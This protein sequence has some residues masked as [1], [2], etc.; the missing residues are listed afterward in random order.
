M[1]WWGQ[2]KG[3]ASRELGG[4]GTWPLPALFCKPGPVSEEWRHLDPISE[5][6]VFPQSWFVFPLPLKKGIET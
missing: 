3:P 4:V 1:V 6:P 2:G 5:I